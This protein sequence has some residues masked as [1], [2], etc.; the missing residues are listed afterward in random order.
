MIQIYYSDI[1]VSVE[2]RI[3]G[4]RSAECIIVRKS[5]LLYYAMV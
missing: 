1:P 5:T 4:G 2:L 3:D